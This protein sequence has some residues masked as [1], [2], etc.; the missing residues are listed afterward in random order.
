VRNL[1]PLIPLAG[2]ATGRAQHTILTVAAAAEVLEPWRQA[3]SHGETGLLRDQICP[4]PPASQYLRLDAVGR[5]GAA[6][7]GSV[8]DS[9]G[10]QETMNVE[11]SGRSAAIHW[12]AKH[13]ERAFT[14][15]RPQV[16]NLSRPPA[17]TGS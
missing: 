5:I 2:V 13:L 10:Q 9:E 11:V 6:D 14:R 16:R 15:Q 1:Q 17:Q 12:D 8:G 3:S 4:S 7:Q